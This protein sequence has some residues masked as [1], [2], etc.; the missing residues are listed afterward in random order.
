MQQLLKGQET[1]FAEGLRVMKSRLSTLHA[2]LAKAA[3]EP[4]AGESSLGPTSC[5]H[6][7]GGHWGGQVGTLGAVTGGGL[8]ISVDGDTCIHVGNLYL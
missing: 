1:R 6:G 2:S 7:L 5:F 3:P 4:P 8:G